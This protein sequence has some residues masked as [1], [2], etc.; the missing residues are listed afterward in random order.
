MIGG[1]NQSLTCRKMCVCAE[2]SRAKFRPSSGI[3]LFA[4]LKL[5]HVFINSEFGDQRREN[6]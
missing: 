4:K 1:L 6:D 2:Y 5:S 3:S